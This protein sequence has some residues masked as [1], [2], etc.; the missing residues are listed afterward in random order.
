MDLKDLQNLIKFVSKSE[1]AEV[2]Y[3]TKD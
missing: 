1:V 2:K 3:K